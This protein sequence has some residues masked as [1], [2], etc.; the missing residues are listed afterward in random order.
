MVF[1]NH[2]INHLENNYWYG[3]FYFIQRN[4][5]ILYNFNVYVRRKRR[6][7]SFLEWSLWVSILNRNPYSI[8]VQNRDDLFW[9]QNRTQRKI[10]RW[11]MCHDNRFMVIL[12]IFFHWDLYQW[13]PVQLRK[14]VT[15][16]SLNVP[17]TFSDHVIEQFNLN[18][19][20]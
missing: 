6:S 19:H 14:G 17:V 5:K 20:H 4:C 1:G 3:K 11:L 10:S 12:P 13:M 8:H 9:L 2:F 16:R 15:F 18:S 7:A